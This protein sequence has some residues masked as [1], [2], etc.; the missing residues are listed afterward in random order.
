MPNLRPVLEIVRPYREERPDHDTEVIRSAMRR[1]ATTDE[2]ARKVFSDYATDCALETIDKEREAAEAQETRDRA[3]RTANAE[4][5]R[6]RTD[7]KYRRERE[8]TR[9]TQRQAARRTENA[10]FES[11][12][13]KTTLMDKTLGQ[14][15]RR[16]NKQ[17]RSF[18]DAVERTMPAWAVEDSILEKTHGE[19]INKLR[20]W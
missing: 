16:E 14:I 4:A 9:E 5:D 11:L 8:Q 19:K 18:H 13:S 1:R 12:L 10:A 17:L 6:E 20:T 15:S 2:N 7:P 3:T